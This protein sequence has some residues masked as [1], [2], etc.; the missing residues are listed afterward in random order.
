MQGGVHGAHSRYSNHVGKVLFFFVVVTL[1][2]FGA[3]LHSQYDLQQRVSSYRS[4]LRT[5][6][7]APR[8]GV[9]STPT[10]E[11][12]VARAEALAHEFDLEVS[13]LEATVTENAT[14]TG[15]SG[16]AAVCCAV[17]A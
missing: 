8:Q 1:A 5:R 17:T 11:D 6:A 4:A 10:E 15:A 3:R 2:V 7:L 14:P 12:I 13:E 9:S 16:M